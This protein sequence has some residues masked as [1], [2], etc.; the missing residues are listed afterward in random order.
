MINEVRKQ[1][2]FVI[3]KIT[4][5][6]IWILINGKE[7]SISDYELDDFWDYDLT[8]KRKYKLLNLNEKH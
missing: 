2:S 4:G 5:D 8:T 3:T 7:Y 1:K 6:L